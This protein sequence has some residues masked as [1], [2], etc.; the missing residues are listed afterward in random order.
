MAA[1]NKFILTNQGIELLTDLM[2]G[3]GEMEFRYL[4]V[5][6]G[7]Y[8][9]E[10]SLEDIREMKRLKN[11]RQRVPF[12]SIKSEDG[13]VNL[14]AN[15][16]NERL[17]EGYLMT[18]A[19]IY[20]GKKGE[21]EEILYCVSSVE[22][23][24]YMPDFS[25]DQ[26]YNV[27]YNMTISIGDVNSATIIYRTDVY[28]LAEDLHA[29][30]NRA[31]EKES[32]LETA[33]GEKADAE[34]VDRHVS[35]AVKHVTAAERTN[36]NDANTKKH[37][38]SNK[39]VL[40]GIASGIC[41]T[42]QG[43]SAKIVDSPGFELQDGARILVT[44]SNGNTS[45]YMTL[46]V[47]NTGAFFAW[48]PV[49]NSRKYND[50]QISKYIIA[51]CAY[52][53]IYQSGATP[54]WVYCG[55]VG[56]IADM[57]GRWE[58]PR[59]INGLMIDGTADRCNYGVCSTAANVYQ[60][61]VS[62]PGFKLITGAE[63]TVKFVNGNTAGDFEMNVNETGSTA[64][65][66]NNQFTNI[67][68]IENSIYKF[69]YDGTYWNFIGS[70][71]TGNLGESVSTQK[72]STARKIGNANFDGTSN[73]TLSQIGAAPCV[74]VDNQDFDNMIVPGIYTMTNARANYP[75][76]GA[77]FKDYGLIV[78]KTGD[79]EYTE[80]IAAA[81][82]N[83][84][85]YIRAGSGD[86]WT[87]WSKLEYGLANS[88]GTVNGV[89]FFKQGIRVG[90]FAVGA[91]KNGF[92]HICQIKIT[93]QYANQPIEFHVLQRDRS[94]EIHLQ[95][96]S[97]AG[98]DPDVFYLRKTG[99]IDAYMVKISA[100]TWDLY[101]KKSEGYDDISVTE[102]RK[103]GYMD[104]H[105]TIAWKNA[106]VT[107]LPAGYITAVAEEYNGNAKSA[108]IL[109]N[110]RKIEFNRWGDMQGKF[111]FNGSKDENSSLYFPRVLIGDEPGKYKIASCSIEP[112][113]N[114][115]CHE[116]IC[117]KVNIAGKVGYGGMLSVV[118]G[119][120]IGNG[121]HSVNCGA[122]WEYAN[123]Y[124]KESVY[125]EIRSAGRDEYG[126]LIQELWAVLQNSEHLL[127]LPLRMGGDYYDPPSSSWLIESKKHGDGPDEAL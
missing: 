122:E 115:D 55:I 39:S 123:G 27:I 45:N 71:G 44:F 114:M 102:L 74:E 48:F 43:N 19:G 95:F 2:N 65:R 112:S 4:A 54:K 82:G 56:G 17:E 50:I 101:V 118:A 15:I 23:P 99:N 91:G 68:F 75:E 97:T 89:T 3:N 46:N 92:I 57:A 37:T 25:T 62:C 22:N 72:L 32:Q 24:D 49:G 8:A 66:Y 60:K 67:T 58:T 53:F 31:K 29:E 113:P 87:A 69:V 12:S 28:A 40:D 78:F 51:G 124:L 111:Y 11:E 42:A 109:A 90:D 120:Y 6:S 34:L 7:D 125:F 94:G 76:D 84:C 64:V 105:V 59:N 38:H 127:L 106:M 79:G 36:W 63:I 21:Q 47:N 52:E 16:T 20:A 26:I 85:L 88:G 83:P 14:K 70:M 103:G 61:S 18:E 13:F 96:K 73:I 86:V 77:V 107:S 117:F 81:L 1:Y 33:I 5:G 121:I 41:N 116:N 110:Q 119:A 9:D 10:N 126:G 104:S 100:N 98:M 93:N 108:A 30:T 80:Q 35:D